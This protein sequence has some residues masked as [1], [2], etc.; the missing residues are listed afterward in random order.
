LF[1]M[2]GGARLTT[3]GGAYRGFYNCFAIRLYRSLTNPVTGKK[4]RIDVKAHNF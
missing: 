4:L 1:L 3:V 2:V